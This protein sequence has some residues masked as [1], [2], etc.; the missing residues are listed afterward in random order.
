[1]LNEPYSSV[2]SNTEVAMQIHVSN[3]CQVAPGEP[4][5]RVLDVFSSSQQS[6]SSIGPTVARADVRNIV[7]A[8]LLP[9][10][11]FLLASCVHVCVFAPHV[12]LHCMYYA[13]RQSYRSRCLPFRMF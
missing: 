10:G 3:N 4:P 5:I 1:M 2:S 7:V 11:L 6:R 13:E 12:C 8:G 9:S